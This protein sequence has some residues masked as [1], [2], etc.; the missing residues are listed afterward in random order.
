MTASAAQSDKLHSDKLK[1]PSRLL[2]LSEGRGLHEFASSIALSPLL[3]LAPRGDG[4]PVLALPGFLAGDGSTWLI[5]RFLRSLGYRAQG[6]ELGRNIG[7][8]YRM[9][10]VLRARL[11]LLRHETGDTLS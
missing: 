10:E 4:H 3:R 6:W 7:G 1:P 2:L 8:F 9:R 5:R 11:A